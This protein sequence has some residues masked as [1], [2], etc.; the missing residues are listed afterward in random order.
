MQQPAVAEA[1]HFAQSNAEANIETHIHLCEIA[2]PEF[3]EEK[4]AAAVEKLFKAAH[5]QTY[6]QTPQE[7]SSATDPA[8]TRILIS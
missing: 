5:L 6:I 2:A 7:T 8:K 4:R 3:H 1:L